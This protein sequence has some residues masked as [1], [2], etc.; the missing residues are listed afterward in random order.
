[1]DPVDNPRLVQIA[2]SGLNEFDPG[3]LKPV[4]A[5]SLFFCNRPLVEQ[6][7]ILAHE[8][9]T[10]WDICFFAKEG[11]TPNINGHMMTNVEYLML[12]GEQ[13]PNAGMD[14]SLYYK[15]FVGR[16]EAGNYVA[17]QKPLALV[18]KWVQLYALLGEMV[19]DRF[20]GTGTTLVACARLGRIGYGCDIDPNMVA[21]TLERL[22]ALGLECSRVE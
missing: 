13:D 11:T 19:L 9:N 5:T 20:C 17:W 12:L 6:Y 18:E 10:N 8:W 2:A 22:N 21:V 3:A 4:A 16:V 7:I 14:Y 1:M 15:H